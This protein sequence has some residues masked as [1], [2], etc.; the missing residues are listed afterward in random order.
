MLGKTAGGLFWMYR[1]LER[2]ENTARLI[3][4]GFRMALTGSSAAEDEWSSILTTTGMKQA[5]LEVH[6]GFNTDTVIDFMLRDRSNPSSV[7]SLVNAARNNARMVRTALT[8]EVWEATN[9]AWLTLKDLLSRAGG[10]AGPA[11]R[12]RHDP[13]S[14]WPGARGRCTA[15]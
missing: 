4:A 8:R 3:D 12:A 7:M 13:A 5:Y 10:G 9:E 1:Y 11:R 15:R 6:D 14:Q 2:S